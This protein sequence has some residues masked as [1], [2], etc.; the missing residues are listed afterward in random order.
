MTDEPT[1]YTKAPVS[2]AEHQ[3]RKHEKAKLWTPRDA[4]I[5]TLRRIDAGEFN[6]VSMVMVIE[7]DSEY[8][9]VLATPTTDQ[10]IALFYHGLHGE[11]T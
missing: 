6:A 11:L 8:L 9:S 4:L 3:A 2:I 5:N 7:T 1:D 10:S